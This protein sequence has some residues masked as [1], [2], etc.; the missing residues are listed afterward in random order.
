ML[1]T[2][3]QGDSVGNENYRLGAWGISTSLFR[4]KGLD[5]NAIYSRYI[6]YVGDSWRLFYLIG[7]N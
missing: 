1:L 2:I 7:Y 4:F 3:P 5:V 6:L